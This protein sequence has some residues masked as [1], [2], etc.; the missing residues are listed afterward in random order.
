M[1]RFTFVGVVAAA[2]LF[3]AVVDMALTPSPPRPL[4][5]APVPISAAEVSDLLAQ[6]RTVSRNDYDWSTYIHFTL[7][8]V[9]IKISS[10]NGDEHE[11]TAPTPNSVVDTTDTID[12]VGST[13][14]RYDGGVR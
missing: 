8:S 9:K 1:N 3:G 4:K 13:G 10:K 5:P 6:L 14:R 7:K 2:A 11:V 12:S